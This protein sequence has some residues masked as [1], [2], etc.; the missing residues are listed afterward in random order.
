MRNKLDE[1]SE[2]PEF[3]KFLEKF[4]RFANYIAASQCPHENP[5][6]IDLCLAYA[7]EAGMKADDKPTP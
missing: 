1:M 4:K 6:A 5:H 7:F 2:K 3:L